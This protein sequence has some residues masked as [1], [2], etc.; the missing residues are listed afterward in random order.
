MIA[1]R[2]N[3]ENNILVHD[4]ILTGTV[5]VRRASA[6]LYCAISRGQSRDGGSLADVAPAVEHNRRAHPTSGWLSIA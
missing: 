1:M 5:H 6:E 2:Q 4:A 3:F